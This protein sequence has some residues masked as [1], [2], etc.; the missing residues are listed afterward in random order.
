MAATSLF[1]F[2]AWSIPAAGR[3]FAELFQR[4]EYTHGVPRHLLARMAQQ[5][6]NYDPNARSDAGAVGIMQIVPR[7]H[8]TVNAL[9]PIAAIDYAGE[10]L[11]RHF[12]RFGSWVKALG[13]YNAG[14]TRLAR[15]VSAGGVNWLAGMPAETQAYIARI[16]ADVRV[17]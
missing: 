4:A 7:W 17:S 16:T 6:S 12:D 15:E 14:P 11:R 10:L 2:S 8:P 13:A 9:D 3:R 5:E 1:Y